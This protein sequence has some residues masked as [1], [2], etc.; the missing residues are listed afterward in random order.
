MNWYITTLLNVFVSEDESGSS[1][2]KKLVV[3]VC[4]HACIPNITKAQINLTLGRT[5]M[6]SVKIQIETP[7]Y[8]DIT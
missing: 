4:P 1:T 3:D 7:W 8:V 5:V 6:V 2:H